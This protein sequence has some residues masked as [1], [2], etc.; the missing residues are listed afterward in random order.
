M[1]D[2]LRTL[3]LYIEATVVK[4][5]DKISIRNQE[6]CIGL[7]VTPV[8]SEIYLGSLDLLLHGFIQNVSPDDIFLRRYVDETLV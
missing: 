6:V 1:S 5:D 8:L 3:E 2:F 7:A 4:Y